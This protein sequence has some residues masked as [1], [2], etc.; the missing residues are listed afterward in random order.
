[1]NE[2]LVAASLIAAT[3]ACGCSRKDI[4][5]NDHNELPIACVLTALTPEQRSQEA[6]L[7]EEHLASIEEVR[8]RD[9]GYAFRYAADAGL[10]SRMAELVALEHRCCPFLDFALEWSHG[11]SEPWLH[12]KGGARGKGFVL[13]TFVPKRGPRG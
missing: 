8:E 7:L 1:M 13:D 11:N 6:V 10:F 12:V 2:R 4:D 3:A 5:V 9:D